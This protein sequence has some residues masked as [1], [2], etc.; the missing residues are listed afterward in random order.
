MKRYPG[1]VGC[2]A[3][4]FFLLA[5]CS[6]D[7][8][9]A[10]ADDAVLTAS[11]HAGLDPQ[12]AARGIVASAGWEIAPD[13]AAAT[14]AG[15]WKNGAP[16]ACVE[17]F[18]RTV[19]T[20]D[21]AHYEWKLRVGAGTYDVI[22]LHRVVRESRPG[23]PVSVRANLFLQHGDY[24]T[25]AGCF[26]PGVVSPRLADDFGFAV[27]AAQNNID[28]WGIDQAWCLVPAEETDLAFMADWDM[29]R[30]VDDLLTAME[31]ARST[32]R[33]TGNGYQPLT[34]GGYS[35]G[36]PIGFA[37]LNQETQLP[38]GLRRIGGF[39]PVDQGLKTDDPTWA[40]VCC[41]V[42]ANY[43]ALID[44]GQYQDNNPLPVFGGLALSDP[45]GESPLV[46]GVTNLQA[47]LIL[48]TLPFFEGVTGHFF[49]G[50]FDENG[51]PTGLR[52]A[53]TDV[54]VDFLA[55]APPYEPAAFL[56]DEYFPSCSD[57]SPY[58]DHLGEI[59]VP[60]LFVKARG[61]FGYTGTRTLDL[62]GSTDVSIHEVACGAGDDL[63]EFG[64]VDLFLAPDAA[65]LAWQPIVEWVRSHSR[66]GGYGGPWAAQD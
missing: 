30:Q 4:M 5:G 38:P 52:L 61:G 27:F 2:L 45:D 40:E 54:L 43:Q 32:R 18:T 23:R 36:G 24:K 48:G 26:L 19:I 62:L 34:L 13:Q 50:I 65:S 28:V 9:V 35:T 46:P 3:V 56:R 16:P 55:Y 10:P 63:L 31:V 1:I 53:D 8:A 33:M 64:H 57:D 11:G 21:I 20:G 47:A 15:G 12:A 37:A 7:Q 29:Q 39:I 49:A 60:I 58:D 6:H 41:A 42:S 17:D 51:L 14:G 44:G 25:F 22:G 59:T 66:P